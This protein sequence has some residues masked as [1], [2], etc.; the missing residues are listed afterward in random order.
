[1]GLDIDFLHQL[2]DARD[3]F[4]ATSPHDSII[5]ERAQGPGFG[6]RG[7][8]HAHSFGALQC[9]V[10]VDPSGEARVKVLH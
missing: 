6:D 9:T 10:P 8:H 1:M 2:D 3:V 5:R 7:W 4:G